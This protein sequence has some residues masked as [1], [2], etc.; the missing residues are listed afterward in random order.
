MKYGY[1]NFILEILEY[2]DKFD[3][4][5][6]EQYYMNLLKPEYNVLLTA[7][8]NLGFKH[9]EGTIEVYRS[10][11]LGIKRGKSLK[12]SDGEKFTHNFDKIRVFS[13]ATR[14]KLSANNHKSISVILRDIEKRVIIRF[15]L[16]IKLLNF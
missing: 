7:G 13:E 8:S 9:S 1:S 3:L 5:N 10:T 14:L 11:R 15:P 2:C 4:L 12:F 16:K 6:R